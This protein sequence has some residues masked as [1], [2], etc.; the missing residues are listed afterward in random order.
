MLKVD[1]VCGI[2]PD[3]NLINNHYDL[4]LKTLTKAI[5]I[6][7]SKDSIL[8]RP[9]TYEPFEISS[10]GDHFE[11]KI[12]GTGNNT[13]C[14]ESFF[15]GFFDFTYENL[16]IENTCIKSSSSNFS[17]KD[18]NFVSLNTMQ[19][20]SYHENKSEDHR[21]HIIFERCTF[22]HNFQIVVESGSYV[23]TFKSCIIKG[24]I[25]LVYGK[26][27]DITIKIS[28]TDFEYPIFSNKD[29]YAE[30]QH[31]VCNFTCP[32]Y[33]GKETLV[34]TKDNLQS[35]SPLQERGRSISNAIFVNKGNEVIDD[36]IE[37]IIEEGDNDGIKFSLLKDPKNT[38]SYQRELYGAI[39]IDS[40]DFPTL[41]LFKFTRLVV[42]NGRK[43]LNIILPKEAENGHQLE[44]F[45]KGPLIIN[46][47]EY[48]CRYIKM[49][50]IFSYGWWI[51]PE[52]L[53]LW[54]KDEESNPI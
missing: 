53:E 42:N 7:K 18:V 38:T 44:I 21:T 16:K 17:Y 19:L 5:K 11:L 1:M 26:R 46:S 37:D 31:T 52:K 48:K 34:Y 50:W 41:E 4:T 51:Y 10:R 13:I 9:G 8:L 25:P 28:N 24:K 2:D 3:E 35:V 40:S 12:I 43:P 54:L 33:K 23:L 39:I 6:S 47:K 49:A 45:S 32:I 36:Y 30:I 20:Q 29:C 27:G 14:S 15:E 22:N